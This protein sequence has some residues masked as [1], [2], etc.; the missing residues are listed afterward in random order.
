MNDLFD[1]ESDLE[2]LDNALESIPSQIP[3]SDLFNKEFMK[4]HTS[5]E[6][7]DK[8]LTAGGYGTTTEEFEAIPDDEFDDYIRKHTDFDNWKEMQESAITEYMD[9]HLSF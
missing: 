5:F 2:E 6:S 1:L 9:S 3:L 7:F 4:E 8:L